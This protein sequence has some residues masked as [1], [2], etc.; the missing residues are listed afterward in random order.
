MFAVCIS[1]LENT[2]AIP[3]RVKK[4]FS[5]PYRPDTSEAHLDSY[6]MGTGDCFPRGKAAGSYPFGSEVKYSGVIPPLSTRL[7]EFLLN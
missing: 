7:Y 6:V 3:G 4:C 2:V 5:F 1:R